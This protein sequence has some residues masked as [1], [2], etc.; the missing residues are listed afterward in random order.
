MRYATIYADPPW[1][2][3]GGRLTGREGFADA[4]NGPSKPLAYPTMSVDEISALPVS[5]VAAD[6]A[7][8]YLWTTN[9][10]LPQAFAVARSWGFQYST[11][12]VWTKRIMGGG[13]GGAFGISTEFLLFCRRGSLAH[14][15]KH[16]G[17]H[18]DFKRPYDERGK[19]MHS[20]KPGEFYAVIEQV[21]PGPYLELFARQNRLGWDAWGNECLSDI[22][23]DK[24]MRGMTT[25]AA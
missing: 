12:L 4:Y 9:G 3:M 1:D 19:P 6:N 25:R 18:F 16:E 8:L 13:L 21:S 23:V 17:T 11:T 10:Y 14:Q 15:A 7:H 22:A 5:S 2:V 20:A 24:A